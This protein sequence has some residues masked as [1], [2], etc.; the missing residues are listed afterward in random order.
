MDNVKVLNADGDYSPRQLLL[1]ALEEVDNIR[2]IAVIVEM[3]PDKDD[4][5]GEFNVYWNTAPWHKVYLMFGVGM[6]KIMGLMR[7]DRRTEEEL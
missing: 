5:E 6:D 2:T 3:K 7:G 1:Q 4:E